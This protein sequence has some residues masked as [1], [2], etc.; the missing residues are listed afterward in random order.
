MLFFCLILGYFCC[1]CCIFGCYKIT[2]CCCC[3]DL[4][5]MVANASMFWYFLLVRY[6]SG[7]RM[8][9]ITSGVD[10]EFTSSMSLWVWILMALPYM[11]ECLCSFAALIYL[12]WPLLLEMTSLTCE[13]N[14]FEDYLHEFIAGVP[15]HPP[16]IWLLLFLIWILKTTCMSLL[17]VFLYTHLWFDC[18]CFWVGWHFGF[19]G[20]KVDFDQPTC[21]ISRDCFSQYV[22]LGSCCLWKNEKAQWSQI[23]EAKK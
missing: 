10:P 16:M 6:V 14:H 19:I 13:W 12:W 2:R 9:A 21:E 7:D 17:L 20:G 11:F 5:V 1:I 4:H 3:Y 18:C 15:V 22:V 8:G 23:T